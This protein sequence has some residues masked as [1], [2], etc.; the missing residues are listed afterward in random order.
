[1]RP[2]STAAATMFP[3]VDLFVADGTCRP[4]AEVRTVGL[5]FVLASQ[6]SP[7]AVA[8]GC[9]TRF[10]RGGV[11]GEE[12][13]CDSAPACLGSRRFVIQLTETRRTTGAGALS[14][15]TQDVHRRLT[16]EAQ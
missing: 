11:T 12:A 16:S 3:R 8:V 10:C 2:V 1:M 4:A 14:S 6:T 13:C 15:H 5:L 7:G 9:F